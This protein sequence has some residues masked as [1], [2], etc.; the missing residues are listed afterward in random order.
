MYTQGIENQTYKRPKEL[1]KRAHFITNASARG[2]YSPLG[3]IDRSAA[4]HITEG[5]T[6]YILRLRFH[7][8]IGL[9]TIVHTTA[10]HKRITFIQ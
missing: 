8:G 10:Y 3:C 1:L 4:P 7:S 9:P 5:G 2:V 6:L